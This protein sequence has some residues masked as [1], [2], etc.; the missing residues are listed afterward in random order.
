M[1]WQLLVDVLLARTTGVLAASSEGCRFVYRLTISGSRFIK[2]AIDPQSKVVDQSWSINLMPQIRLHRL[3]SNSCSIGM[4]SWCYWLLFY[5][6]HMWTIQ[7]DMS[8]T[9]NYSYWITTSSLIG[10]SCILTMSKLS[11]GWNWMVKHLRI[12]AHGVFSFL[13]FPQFGMYS[14]HNFFEYNMCVKLIW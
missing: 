6:Q 2:V 7:I 8:N 1:T 12:Q 11:S 13:L 5:K 10:I 14:D 4:D 3:G 9:A